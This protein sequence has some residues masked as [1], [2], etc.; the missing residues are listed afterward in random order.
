MGIPGQRGGSDMSSVLIKLMA[1][2]FLFPYK[3]LFSASP[4]EVQESWSHLV[5]LCLKE[6][7]GRK[8]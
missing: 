7:P 5:L 3:P 1:L 4:L 8:G 2:H 6:K